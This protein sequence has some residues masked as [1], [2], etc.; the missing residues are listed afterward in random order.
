MKN[1]VYSKKQIGILAADDSLIYRRMISM[2]V[3]RDKRFKL[4]GLFKNGRELLNATELLHYAPTICLLDIKMPICNGIDAA[5][6]LNKNYHI[7]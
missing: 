3:E 1:Q 4:L 5:E 7:Y 6:L 2:M